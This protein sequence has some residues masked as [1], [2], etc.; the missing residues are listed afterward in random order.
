MTGFVHDG[1]YMY[2]HQEAVSLWEEKKTE[3]CVDRVCAPRK[4]TLDCV[5]V[6]GSTVNCSNGRKLSKHKENTVQITIVVF[7]GSVMID[8]LCIIWVLPNIGLRQ[9]LF[10]YWEH[11]GI[12]SVVWTHQIITDIDFSLKSFAVCRANTIHNYI[13]ENRRKCSPPKV[14]SYLRMQKKISILIPGNWGGEETLNFLDN[15]L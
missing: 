5:F 10:L 1:P 3:W 8:I 12:C 15:W 9:W 2:F 4:R 11:C 14:L 13:V 7:F 6:F